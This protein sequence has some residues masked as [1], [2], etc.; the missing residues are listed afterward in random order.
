MIH[1]F[2]I[3]YQVYP[4]DCLVCFC[5]N[6]NDLFNILDKKGI[7]KEHIEE[8]KTWRFAKGKSAMLPTGQSFIWMDKKPESCEDYGILAHEIFHTV[9]FLMDRIGVKYS[10]EAD[11]AFAYMIGYLTTEILKGINKMK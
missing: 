11:E 4:F 10:N 7:L 1:N 8:V 6:P 5:E 2:I 9:C 3:K